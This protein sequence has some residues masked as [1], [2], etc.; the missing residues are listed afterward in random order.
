[1]IIILK[2]MLLTINVSIY[3]YNW[4]IFPS[5]FLT[6]RTFIRLN[7][8]NILYKL[9]NNFKEKNEITMENFHR[10]HM[11]GGQATREKSP[12]FPLSKK[13]IP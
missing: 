13:E 11:T 4:F 2:T 3:F 1:M 8:L 5:S 10:V 12:S 9:F 7:K 6:H